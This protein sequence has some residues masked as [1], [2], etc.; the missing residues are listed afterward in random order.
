MHRPNARRRI[1]DEAAE[2][3]AR[4]NARTVS[5]SDLEAFRAWRAV[6]EHRTAYEAVE[7]AWRTAGAL[8]DDPEIQAALA[9]A[10]VR[11]ARRQRVRPVWAFAGAAAAAAA[12]I[13]GVWLG[14]R[15]D[16]F[17]TGIGERRVVRL[18]DGSQLHLDTASAVTVRLG[19]ERRDLELVRGQALFQVAPDPGRPFTVRAGEVRVT[20]TGTLFDVRRAGEQVRVTLVEGGVTVQS[21]AGRPRT[22]RLEP[23]QQIIAGSAAGAGADPVHVDT[24]AATAWTE[25]RIEFDAVPLSAALAEVNRYETRP[26]RLAGGV[27]PRLPVSG[28]FD[29]GHGLAFAEAAARIHGLRVGAG[30]AVILLEPHP[31]EKS[32]RP[33]G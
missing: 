16:E 5:V 30:P 19:R 4:L 12:V 23:S 17:S 11:P 31:D 14:A 21:S 7:T 20:A 10:V 26:V 6:P 22:W 28:V 13:A 3:F 32:E 1:R 24:R 27:D 25:G 2:W 8:R 33:P 15:P 18:A 29:A 9:I